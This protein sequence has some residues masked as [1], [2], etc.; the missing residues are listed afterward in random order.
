MTSLLGRLVR[1]LDS[2]GA[3]ITD[4]NPLP[5]QV[6]GEDMARLTWTFHIPGTLAA[7]VNIRWLVSDSCHLSHV[8]AGA[9]NSNDALISF[10]ISTDPDSI[11]A[12]EPIGDS[13]VPVE[14]EAGDW[15]AANE[16]AALV[17]GQIAV[18]TVDHDG[19]SG[20]AAADVTIVITAT[21]D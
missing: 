4:A 13:N 19:A 20:T 21:E 1:L 9:S 11:L 17:N 2:E 7:D 12:A 8:S 15:D 18:L 3:L 14:F 6:I 16:E 10:G 5:V